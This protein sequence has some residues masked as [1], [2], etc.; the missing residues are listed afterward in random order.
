MVRPIKYYLL[1]INYGGG[2][3][4]KRDSKGCFEW[5][6]LVEISDIV[7][8]L[9]KNSGYRITKVNREVIDHRHLNSSTDKA[10]MWE[11]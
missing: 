5:Q 11:G 7:D 1:E 8:K 10:H 2:W 9:P 6:S 3:I 4:E